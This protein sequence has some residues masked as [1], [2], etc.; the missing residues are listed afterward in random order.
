MSTFRRLWTLPV[1]LIILATMVAGCAAPAPAAD[2][3]NHR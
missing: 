2:Q 1:V 3:W